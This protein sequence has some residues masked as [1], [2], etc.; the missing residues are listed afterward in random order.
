L[1]SYHLVRIR[2]DP[3]TNLIKSVLIEERVGESSTY[4]DPYNVKW[5]LRNDLGLFF[6]VIYQG[7]LKL[8]YLDALLSAV[9]KDFVDLLDTSC[10][11][12]NY[13]PQKYDDRFKMLLQTVDK[14]DRKM[15]TFE[16][17]KKGKNKSGAA[18]QQESSRCTPKE[19][20]GIT[21]ADE[22]DEDEDDDDGGD[23]SIEA[24]K[25]RLMKR[26]AGGKKN[27]SKK[28]DRA[29][30]ETPEKKNAKEARV[31]AG[32]GKVTAQSM[33]KLDMSKNTDV[34]DISKIR[35]EFMGDE[36]DEDA[37]SVSSLD[38]E[39]DA[40]EGNKGIFSKLVS[41]VKNVTGGAVLTE[42]SLIPMT[43]SFERALME[44]NV[45]SE[46][47]EKISESVR[48]TLAGTTTG[49]FTSVNATI[50]A[51]L[52]QAIETILT[53]KKSVDVLRAA[54]AAKAANRVYSVVFIGVNGVG[55]STNLS[56]VAYYLKHKGN[57]NVMMAA[58]DT[59]RAGAVEQLRTH[60]RC[61]D[62]HLFERGYGKD[63]SDIAQKAIQYAG[64]EGYDVVL[65]DTAGRMQ[66]NEPLMK[67][68]AKL[69]Q[70]NNPD[71]VLFVGEA[72]VGNDAIDQVTKF[73]RAL[74][75]LAENRS[76]PRGIDGMLLT[77]YD[78]VDDKVGAALSMVYVTG[79]PIV[80]VGTGQKYPNLRKLE[81]KEVAKQLL[82]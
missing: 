9:K 61:L 8:T 12:L 63:P 40:A 54:L 7:L 33:K 65:V 29:D 34:D 38:E 32:T 72:L 6:V 24:N 74:L 18:A 5:H 49:K 10:N 30:M 51:A 79:Q 45:A 62:C 15:R 4:F 64:S 59:F 47:V 20:N 3:I 46:V 80:F 76:N 22:E 52:T 26:M 75:D 71:L 70:V 67:A 48:K 31:W 44:K 53:P 19:F 2:G 78:T 13:Q 39:A 27:V 43:K 25:K 16:Q 35:A 14:S 28:P 68:L 37:A 73:N 58:C 77:K 17:T 36:D 11:V 69:V 60:A 42:E 50:K 21:G 66:D 56:K 55:K 23:D 41:G 82:S 57:L 1:W 81:V